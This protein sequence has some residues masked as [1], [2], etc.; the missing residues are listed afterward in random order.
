MISSVKSSVRI[1]AEMRK[2]PHV[3]VAQLASMLGISQRVV[4]KNIAKLK[5]SCSIRRN[6]SDVNGEWEVRK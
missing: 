6:G 2:K 5:G 1:I 4:R 3:T